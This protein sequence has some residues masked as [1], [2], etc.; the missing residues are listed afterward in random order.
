MAILQDPDDTCSQE[1]VHLRKPHLLGYTFAF[2]LRYFCIRTTTFS[3]PPHSTHTASHIPQYPAQYQCDS[4]E[5]GPELQHDNLSCIFH[6]ILHS[7]SSV[8]VLLL[9]CLWRIS[10][11]TLP[12]VWRSFCV[13]VCM[14]V[15]LRVCMCVHAV[16][17]MKHS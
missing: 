5:H 1:G 6:Y 8:S 7:H 12:D 4:E 15:C 3:L 11:Y 10:A 14:R 2:I 17:L 16:Q 9:L 13:R